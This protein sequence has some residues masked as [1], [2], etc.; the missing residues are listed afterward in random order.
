MRSMSLPPAFLDEL[1]SRLSLAQVAG[2][3][4]RAGVAQKRGEAGEQ[5]ETG[6]NQGDARPVGQIDQQRKR[7][8][9]QHREQAGQHHQEQ[10]LVEPGVLARWAPKGR[11]R[12]AFRLHEKDHDCGSM[13]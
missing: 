6:P 7:P 4:V 1:R 12:R 11:L 13:V 5:P 9:E 3:K 2:R 8:G 10:E